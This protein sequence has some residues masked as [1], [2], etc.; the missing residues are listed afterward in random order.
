MHRSRLG[1]VIVK[2]LKKPAQTS[3]KEARN[4]KAYKIY[5]NLIWKG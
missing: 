3:F 2:M 4:A 1:K 5:Q